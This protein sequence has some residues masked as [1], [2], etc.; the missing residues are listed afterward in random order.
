LQT[1][2]SPFSV[3]G[4]LCRQLQ[5]RHDIAGPAAMIGASN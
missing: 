1:L 3:T 4:W 5:V 2:T